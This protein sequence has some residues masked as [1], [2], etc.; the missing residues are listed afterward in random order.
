MSHFE[1]TVAEN[2]IKS[3]LETTIQEVNDILE[4]DDGKSFEEKREAALEHLKTRE[5]S[6]LA[7]TLVDVIIAEKEGQRLKN[8]FFASGEVLNAER[9]IVLRK[10][11]PSDREGFVGLLHE[12]SMMKS[13]LKDKAYCDLVWNEHTEDKALTLSILKDGNYIGYCG[14]KNLTKTPWEIVIEIQ[15]KWT[16]HGIGHIAITTMLDEIYTRFGI[17]EYRVRIEPSNYPSQKLFEKL[18]AVPNGISELWIHDQ[19]LLEQCEEDNLHQI[20]DQIIS[21]ANKF[22]VEPRKLLSH[23]LEYTL[24]W[25]GKQTEGD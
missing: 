22:C 25:N 9:N 8:A 7:D 19:E 24:T 23:V 17:T 11:D 3:S 13:M 1:K 4:L 5:D 10:V 12:Y 18:G 21:V 2:S 16:K 20:N 15:S 6:I 14:I